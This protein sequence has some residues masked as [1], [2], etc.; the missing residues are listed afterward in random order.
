ML[1]LIYLAMKK[2]R[3]KWIVLAIV[4]ICGISIKT[5]AQG[6]VSLQVFYDELQPYGT[7]VQH[8]GYGY[9][10]V[11][12]VDRG[13]V[14]YRTNGYW[15]NTEYGN[16]W[17]SDYNW[18][19]AP[20][21][22]GRWFYD[23]FYGWMWAPDT[24]WGPA[25]VVW[26]SGGGYYGWAPLMPGFGINVS[27]NYYNR[28]PYHYW[29]FVPYRYITYR[30]VHMHCVPRT[31]VANVIH[32]TTIVNH[33]YTDNRRNTF[34]TGPSRS[35][36]EKTNHSRVEVHK[37]NE[38]VRPGSSNVDRGTV[39]FYRP[40]IDNSRVLRMK[41]V[42]NGFV[43]D[44]RG[45]DRLESHRQTTSEFKNSKQE[46]VYRYP[47]TNHRDESVQTNN[48]TL[49]KDYKTFDRFQQNDK[50]KMGDHSFNDYKQ[51]QSSVQG[52]HND[53]KVRSRGEFERKKSVEN[54][55]QQR[56]MMSPGSNQESNQK[57][58]KQLPQNIER[59]KTQ[60][61]RNNNSRQEH[62]TVPN[63]R[64]STNHQLR[65]QINKGSSDSNSRSFQP[66]NG[67]SR[68]GK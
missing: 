4:L 38:R 32:H 54:Y 65:Q 6:T 49:P 45:T 50:K 8:A 33:H 40:E 25:W 11:P 62:I 27:V 31:R 14:P 58:Q 44:E 21:H 39:S 53:S 47:A 22:Y 57:V 35:D 60:Q 12:R 5:Q 28:I 66:S 51:G 37:I 15:I 9:A 63:S 19:W 16:T 56:D 48:N 43:K 2:G 30:H 10:W 18:G 52:D 67:R 34:F 3:T 23:D 59:Q 61:F 55:Y 7:W 13:F 41:S 68:G 20:F 46:N 29:N 36:I 42:P 26:R 17:V 24:V 64:S 1:I